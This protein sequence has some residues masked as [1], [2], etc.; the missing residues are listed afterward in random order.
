[1]DTS[2]KNLENSGCLM[3]VLGV[4]LFKWGSRTNTAKKKAR[5]SVTN[6][7]FH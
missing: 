4:F 3:A 5:R 1:M 6:G 7:L 2:K